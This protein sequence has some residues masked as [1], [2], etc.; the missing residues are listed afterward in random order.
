M[1]YEVIGMAIEEF[2]D[3]FMDDP[4]MIWVEST[5]DDFEGMATFHWADGTTQEIKW[6]DGWVSHEFIY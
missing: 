2:M 1:G 6:T 3:E 4:N 5:G